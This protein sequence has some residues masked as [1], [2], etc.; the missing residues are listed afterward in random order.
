V[1]QEARLERDCR[2]AAEE[3]ELRELRRDEE[4]GDPPAVAARV[5]ELQQVIRRNRAGRPRGVPNASAGITPPAMRGGHALLIDGLAQHGLRVR[6]LWRSDVVCRRN[7]TRVPA[8]RP[9][10]QQVVQHEADAKRH[11][12]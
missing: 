2:R 5:R 10:R 6:R 9:R 3:R 11:S 4:R 1:L 7:G 8:V 12:F